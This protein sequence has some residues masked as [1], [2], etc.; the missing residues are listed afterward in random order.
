MTRFSIGVPIVLVAFSVLLVGCPPQPGISVSPTA[1][2]VL[3][4]ESATLTV[5]NTSAKNVTLDIAVTAEPA[6]LTVTDVDG[7]A[8]E[9]LSLEGKAEVDLTIA[10]A[11][12]TVA[13]ADFSMG[14]VTLV[15]TDADGA[16]V[17]TIEVVVDTGAPSYNTQSFDAA[18]VGKIVLFTESDT[19]D[20]YTAGIADM[21]EMRVSL[22]GV[23]PLPIVGSDAIPVLPLDGATVSLYGVD[24]ETFYVGNDG[25][26]TF[27]AT[28]G[29]AADAELFLEHFA[30]PSV[31][32]LFAPLSG[33]DVYAMQLDDRMVIIYDGVQQLD[34]T[35]DNIFQIELFLT[36][37]PEV[38]ADGP[39]I[40]LAWFAVDADLDAVVGLSEGGADAVP[41][42]FT[43]DDLTAADPADNTAPV[44]ASL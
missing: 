17:E 28:V 38:K 22:D 25:R 8:V 26:I 18:L 27:E 13:K 15:A 33:G 31:S 39:S 10:V 4:G 1:L 35:G 19:P 6:W 20:F 41:D 7:V 16:E 32:G 30:T 12:V 23:T 36:P 24:Y 14:A 5:K 11:A 29:A 21:A 43:A 2:D 34:G 44:A 9:A 42:D 37:A 40:A 3:P